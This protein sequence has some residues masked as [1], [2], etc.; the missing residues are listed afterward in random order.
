MVPLVLT[1]MNRI[2]MMGCIS[3]MMVTSVVVSAQNTDNESGLYT[4][5]SSEN[6]VFSLGFIQ[7]NGLIQ[8]IPAEGFIEGFDNL[9]SN[10]SID[11]YVPISL[12]ENLHIF[13]FVGSTSEMEIENVT[14]IP[15]EIFEKND[16]V[17]FIDDMNEIDSFSAI[18]I[19]LSDGLF[20]IGIDDEPVSY[21]YEHETSLS[22]FLSFPFEEF[23]DVN[24]FFSLTETL[25]TAQ[26]DYNG[27]Y[28]MIYPFSEQYTIEIASAM[29]DI[30]W[31]NGPSQSILLLKNNGFSLQEHSYIHIL[32]LPSSTSS[33]FQYTIQPSE[34]T[35][36]ITSMLDHI[37]VFGEEIDFNTIPFLSDSDQGTQLITSLS[38]M[39]NG[40]ILF[41]NHS[42]PVEIDGSTQSFQQ[43]GFTR[44]DQAT[45]TT[46]PSWITVQADYNLVFL[47]DHFYSSQA[48]GSETGVSLPIIPIIL[49]IIA[50]GLLLVFILFHVKK[51]TIYGITDHRIK[52]LS[53]TLHI[54]GYIAAFILLDFAISHQFGIS[55]FTEVSLNG[56]SLV[57][58]IFLLIQLILFLIGFLLFAFPLGIIASKIMEYFGFDKNYRHGMKTFTALSIWPFISL[59]LTMFINVVLLIFNPFNAMI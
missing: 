46:T 27:S 22:G 30:L 47:G 44:V 6:M 35:P 52:Y 4:E 32:P 14:I 3:I 11:Q 12:F 24:S 40:G 2:I 51:D 15:Q 56:M 1:S 26:F 29:G 45:V 37:D 31:T 10:S 33:T 8:G 13:P 57:A 25:S 43:F 54:T 49:W 23:N 53:L 9:S 34:N 39:L 20:L 48:T 17:D 58:G 55:L 19:T 41:I 50:I 38:S 16:S 42:G 5:L 36:D 21:H 7:A 59:Y 28:L 18:T